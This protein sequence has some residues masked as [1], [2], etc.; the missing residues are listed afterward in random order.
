[1]TKSLVNRTMSLLLALVMLLPFC[2]GLFSGSCSVDVY[3]ASNIY[4][5]Q[6]WDEAFSDGCDNGYF[7]NAVQNYLIDV[8][9]GYGFKKELK[10]EYNQIVI[11]PISQ[12]PTTYGKADIYKEGGDNTYYL[13][14][15]KPFSYNNATK[16]E[17][18]IEQLNNYTNPELHKNKY[19]TYIKGGLD[20]PLNHTTKFEITAPNGKSTYEVSFWGTSDSL[21]LY[22]FQ[23]IPD[24][25]DDDSE[26][27]EN[28]NT[29]SD[30]AFNDAH[31][32]A[33]SEAIHEIIDD[34]TI[35]EP[36]EIPSN[37]SSPQMIFT[38]DEIRI[39]GDVVMS[40]VFINKIYRMAQAVLATH[41]PNIGK[42][43]H[44][45]QMT[46]VSTE[47]VTEIDRARTISMSTATKTA[48]AAALFIVIGNFMDIMDVSAEEIDDDD[49]YEEK[50]DDA[51]NEIK[52][53]Q[54]KYEDSQKQY[55]RDPL[56]INFSGKQEIEFT[57]LNDGV[58]FDLDNNGFAE[59]TA[60]IKN[61]DGFL[62][63]D[64][65]NDGMIN[66]GSELFGDCF[67]NQSFSN[68]FEALKGLDSNR[69]NKIDDTDS[70]LITKSDGFNHEDETHT[71]LDDL[72]VWF[73]YNHNGITDDNETK[74]LKSL[75]V[76]YIDLNCFNDQYNDE[77]DKDHVNSARREETSYVYFTDGT[78]RKNISEFWF[79]I[80]TINTTHDGVET[81]GNV[82]TI[83][84]AVKD[85]TTGELIRLCR[86]F[87]YTDSIAKKHY[88]LKKI[89][90]FITDSA[91][92][93]INSR[94]G[95]IDARDLN[96]VEAFM[97]HRFKGVDGENP[98]A[99]A[100]AMLKE[101]YKNIEI[102]YYNALNLKMSFG[103]YMAVT[104]ETTDEE[105]NKYLD[106]SLL[107]EVIESKVEKTDFDPKVMI[108]YLGSYIKYYDKI[109]NTDEFSKF[110]THYSSISPQYA[111]IINLIN[112]FN[113][114]IDSEGDD[115]YYGT[116]ETDLIFGENG[117]N[118][119]SGSYGNDIM[120][121]GYGNDTLVGGAGDDVYYFG[122][123]HGNDI[124][125]DTE[126]NNTLIFLDAIGSESY[127][128]SISANGGFILTNI[129][130]GETIALPDFIHNPENY[131]FIFNGEEAI[132]GGGDSK[133]V[134]T[135]TDSDDSLEAGDGFNIFYG[136]EGN[137]TIEGGKDMDFMYGGAGDDTLLG[138]NGV[139]V[140]FGESGSDTIYD[141]NDGSYLSGG[142][143]D[144]FIYGGGG[145]DVL[146][147][148]T[149][150]DYLQGDHGGD[151][152]IYRK[153][154]DT[155]TIN[156]SSDDNT[157]LIYGYKAN[158]MINTRNAHND[159]I[160]HFGSADSTD[161][162]IIDHFFD[163]NSNRDISFVFDDGTVLGQYDITAKYEPIVG[164]DGNDWLAIQNSDNGI[165]HAGAGND[166]LNGGSGNDELYG[167]EGDDTLYGNDG[168]DVLDGGTGIDTLCGGNGEDTYIFAKGYEQDTINEW[169]SD[170]ST[171][172]LT[173]IN[174][175][176][177][178]V[179]DQWG[180]NLL[181][182][183]ND[184]D[185]VLTISNFKWGQA[186]YTFKFADG[187]EGYVDKDT[188][189]LVL[190]K[191]P[192]V[193]DEEVDQEV[194][195][196]E[197]NSDENT[198]EEASQVEDT[199]ST[200]ESTSAETPTIETDTNT[201]TD[202]SETNLVA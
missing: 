77:N 194:D 72:V 15:V 68:G 29:N 122:F 114:F 83:D 111:D 90:Y 174:S 185:D 36:G 11:N 192:D 51:V 169:G 108:Y 16:R 127:N 8:K 193:V 26:E 57:S 146:D 104:Y 49:I 141:G 120:F 195:N 198:F 60:W 86:A 82:P 126:G 165:I 33:Q 78:A 84:Q 163:Y 67:N 55:Q 87:N 5:E 191:E 103:G 201:E 64:L 52:N 156:A 47:V 202:D 6:D 144:D 151:T 121:S 93:P 66:N 176:E 97:G 180:T 138:R 62:A 200:D 173:D 59:K 74:S 65:N 31:N 149:G 109:N 23:K 117:N 45:G 105:G 167:E 157:I 189:Q 96:V 18:A 131:S 63:I 39:A 1:M 164:T 4:R 38:E 35:I 80:N 70:P 158:Q 92:I 10:I 46:A 134:I 145:A 37:P 142:A 106:T 107:D 89:L 129:E 178:T 135:G 187:A 125:K 123:N 113:T 24:E 197:L 130:T 75:N 101:I 137:D 53:E 159:L 152:Y 61:D 34:D 71:L 44:C 3:A 13:W 2:N 153:G 88:Y 76:D 116:S 140:I 7:H 100:A 186:T 154:Y 54:K 119:F 50:V 177:I 160:I 190:I 73:D 56:I 171:V 148:G 98:N 168:N 9:K 102:N 69:D 58:N 182:S 124:V 147:G 99:P 17:L 183:V 133:D 12:K 188:W 181:I 128:I 115:V 136:G 118:T 30:S 150:N 25:D 40:A 110:K 32:G 79:D 20:T 14:E 95:N 199:D 175:D 91:D 22:K 161:C 41:A 170:H 85:D 21:I 43:S 27:A 19:I 143:D 28:S 172:L 132:L 48:E 94:G 162:L 42:A 196:E 166:G 155:D 81:V 184:T 112:K 179:S 139:N